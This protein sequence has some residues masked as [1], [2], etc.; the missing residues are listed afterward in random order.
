MR[1][2]M[3]IVWPSF[4]AAG[5]LSGV[6][7][8]LIDPTNIFLFGY[9]QLSIEVVY[10]GGFFL[11]WLLAAFSSFLSLFMANTRGNNKLFANSEEDL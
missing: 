10:A 4:L 8:A 2:I 1:T 7:F 3:W 5:L 9:K 6:V 11:F